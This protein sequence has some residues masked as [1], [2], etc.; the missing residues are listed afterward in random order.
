MA[1]LHRRRRRVRPA[2]DVDANGG[3]YITGYTD[4]SGWVSGGADTTFG[5][6]T[7]AFV[8]RIS[9]GGTLEW[10]SYLGGSGDDGGK[11]IAV[12]ANA[13]IYVVGSTVGE[14]AG[15]WVSGGF[16]TSGE[17]SVPS[18]FVAKLGYNTEPSPLT[19]SGTSG[20][21][22]V[23]V[24][25]VGGLVQV[26]LNGTIVT[27]RAIGMVSQVRITTLAGN[28]QVDILAGVP[29]AYIDGGVGNDTITGGDGGDIIYGGDGDD[30]LAGGDG[31][32]TIYGNFGED[33]IAGGLKR[34]SLLGGLGNDTITAGDGPDSV[35]GGD[36]TDVL[37][38]GKG[39]DYIEGRG[40]SDS[41]YG[42]LG[43][44][45]IVSGAGADLVYGEEDDDWLY[46]T[47]ASAFHDTLNGGT[48]TDRYEADGDDVIIAVEVDLLA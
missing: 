8:A 14:A 48:G 15:A 34:D 12:D 26:T 36:G 46:A 44:D 22:I 27:K 29:A 6:A 43:N 7:D 10:S 40:K 25:N 20:D 47:Q 9:P 42:G 39:A 4:L 32:D 11:G 45:T 23:R 24:E 28:D 18:G 30:L 21:D 37:R 38:G 19:A 16:D 13:N 35:Y 33:A 41:I 5:G 17:A 1:D 31:I 2:I 3:S